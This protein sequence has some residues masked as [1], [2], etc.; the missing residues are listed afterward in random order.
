MAPPL[1]AGASRPDAHRRPAATGPATPGLAL[2]LVGRGHRLVVVAALAWQTGGPEP[3]V[4]TQAEVDQLRPA[5]AHQGPRGP[6]GAAPPDAAVVYQTILPSLVQLVS[7]GSLRAAADVPSTG[8]GVVVNADGTI[9]TA[10]HVVEGAEPSRPASPTAR[11]R[12]PRSSARRPRAT[13][14]CCRSTSCPRSSSRR[15]RRRGPGRLPRGR[16]RAPLRPD[17]DAHL[18]G[19]VGPGPLHPPRRRPRALRTDPVR[20]R[21]QP[22]QLRRPA[23]QPRRPGHRH[24]HRPGQPHGPVLLRRHR[25]RRADRDRRRRRRRP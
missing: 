7:T 9:L 2:G 5:A 13:S 25:L 4:L 20:R 1:A 10:L 8:A 19:R 14:P 24:R 12:A 11:G 17:A 21:R 16:R 22:R 3:D 6:A 18:R 23:A 15:A